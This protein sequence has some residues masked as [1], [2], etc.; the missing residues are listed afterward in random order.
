MLVCWGGGMWVVTVGHAS[1]LSLC[2]VVAQVLATKHLLSAT[3][4]PMSAKNCLDFVMPWMAVE[5]C[6]SLVA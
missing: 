5:A 1:A 3:L 6:F 4:A 2:L